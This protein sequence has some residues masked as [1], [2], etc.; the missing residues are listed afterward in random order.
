M[1]NYLLDFKKSNSWTT[2]KELDKRR[3]KHNEV[4][5]KKR[6]EGHTNY[7]KTYFVNILKYFN[8]QQTPLQNWPHYVSISLC[9]ALFLQTSSIV[10][11]FDFLT[12][13][14]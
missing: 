11:L 3:F 5:S 7:S 1:A 9:Q 8:D 14:K 13:S 6:Y 4:N 2:K 12:I 10:Q